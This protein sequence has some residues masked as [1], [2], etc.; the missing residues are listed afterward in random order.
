MTDCFVHPY[1]KKVLEKDVKGNLFGLEGNR[2]DV[3]KCY[4]GCYDFANAI[5]S[6]KE[7]RKV[8]DET[9]THAKKYELTLAAIAEPWFDRMKPWYKTMLKSLGSLSGRRVL[10]LGNGVSHREFYFLHLGARVVFTDLSLIAVMHAQATFRRS[11]L[12]GMH[13]GNI[14]FHA[15][16]AMHMPFPD[17]AFDVIY[18]TKFVG[19]VDNL[20]DFFSEVSRCL[21]PGG[22]C[23]FTDDA[24]SPTWNAIR[25]TIS[26]PTKARFFWKSMSDLAK[27]RS[28][29]SPFGSFG[30]AE[31]SVTMFVQQFG[32]AR[33][34]F[35]REFF[36]LRLAELLWGKLVRF[37]SKRLKYARPL[38]LMG[39]WI[40]NRLA[41]TEWMRRN[42]LALTW[43]FDK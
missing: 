8:Y 9:Y 43:G 31:E 20:P 39:K 41:R 34:V 3:Y 18:G 7:K 35:I 32:F 4:E 11:E 24:Y 25:R 2:C 33:L 42:R 5:P 6:V 28:G 36:F 37:D 40:D 10:L 38:Y 13:R 16:D 1:T 26:E 21:R 29:G 17:A 19:F 23:R 15:V 12:F 14:E 27:I 22:I 30:F